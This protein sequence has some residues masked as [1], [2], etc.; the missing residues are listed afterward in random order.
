MPELSLTDT[1]SVIDEVTI[2]LIGKSVGI[3]DAFRIG[4]K[5]PNSGESS[6]PRPL[7][8]KLDSC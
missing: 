7:L 5:K 8:I 3:R 2:H 1:K 6:H 4:R